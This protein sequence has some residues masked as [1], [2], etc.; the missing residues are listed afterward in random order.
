MS[1]QLPKYFSRNPLYAEAP[2]VLTKSVGVVVVIP[3]FKEENILATL[4]SLNSCLQP[5][6]D[7]A[8]VIVNN[9]PES[10]TDSEKAE[11][12]ELNKTIRDFE[13][14]T[15]FISFTTIEA[16]N[17]PSKSFGAGLARKIGM[18]M[19]A[20][21][22]YR[23]G[24][25][26]CVI[27]SLD[28]DCT[29]QENYFVELF[30]A[31]HATRL[32]GAS[33]YFEHPLSG[34]LPDVNYQA[35][36]QYELHLRYYNLMLQ[37]V[38]FPN[39]FHTVGS[40]FAVR[41]S[42]YVLAGGMTK[43][44]AGEDFY[45]I[46]KLLAMGNYGE[47]NSTTV[48]PSARLS[49]RV[50][51]GTGAAITKYVNESEKQYFTFNPDSFL[52]L[53]ELFLSKALFYTLDESCWNERLLAHLPTP[54]SD[55]VVSSNVVSLISKLKANCASLSVFESRFYSLFDGLLIVRYLNFAHEGYF[56]K[57]AVSDAMRTY[58]NL[59]TITNCGDNYFEMLL[60]FRASERGLN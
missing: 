22:L 23:L 37:F 35:I 53:K 26:H 52:P 9:L 48:Y 32:S 49:S 56:S 16:F 60:T 34:A 14:K 1:L 41:C 38:G 40:S 13:G 4:R 21:E 58:C 36:A 44:I 31:F 27:A 39:G 59:K 2:F 10:A 57:V 45:F 5:P 30:K 20:Y 50:L 25:E 46:Q 18:D 11:Q 3:A 51:F 24:M 7:V 55:F 54:L 29:V 12:L 28:A 19:V 15:S 17:L 8:V 43:K 6:C 47:I 42:S 33:I